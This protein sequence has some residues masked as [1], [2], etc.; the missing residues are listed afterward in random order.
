MLSNKEM[1]KDAMNIFYLEYIQMKAN[2]RFSSPGGRII[3]RGHVKY[4]GIFSKNK[5]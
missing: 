4:V 2:R 1:F 5:K 3:A